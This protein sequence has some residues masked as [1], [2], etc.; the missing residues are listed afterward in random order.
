VIFIKYGSDYPLFI[1][2]LM[3]EDQ[4]AEP[5]V[6]LPDGWEVVIETP[7]PEIISG[8][9]VLES[10]PIRDGSFW[11]QQ[12]SLVEMTEEEKTAMATK[13]IPVNPE[14]GEPSVVK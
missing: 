14:T 9:K 13:E 11:K 10:F 8:Y 4:N 2:D 6:N 5:H 3:N 7:K 12:W 1:G